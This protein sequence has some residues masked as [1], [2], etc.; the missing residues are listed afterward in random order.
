MVLLVWP[1][2]G[3]LVGPGSA[4]AARFGSHDGSCTAAAK[5]SSSKLCRVH[6]MQR[7]GTVNS[8]GG[9]GATWV[10][11]LPRRSVTRTVA[12]CYT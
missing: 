11:L 10:V 12:V 6:A 7:V 2:A 3:S 1:R 9:V 8:N 5:G 4:S